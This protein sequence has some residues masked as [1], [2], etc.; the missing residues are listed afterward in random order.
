MVQI[1]NKPY[2][3][4]FLDRDG[5][6]NVERPDDYVKSVD[7]FV[8]E[9]NA[10]E[11]IA[12]LSSFFDHIFIITNQ[13]G[14]GRGIMSPDTLNDIHTYM[15]S[16]IASY[17]GRIDKIYCCTHTDPTCINRKPNTGMAFRVIGDYP[18][19]KF[20][21]TVMAGNSRS[22]ISFARKLGIYAVLVG[23][24]Y[25][26]RDDI[27]RISDACYEN[28]YKFALSLNLK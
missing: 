20:S 16:R 27:Y 12:I 6:I 17:G 4:L 7:E 23:D 24:K 8:F 26:A 5:V 13:R 19:V 11:A 3:T 1:G 14:V 28:L 22:D 25:P 9:E 21:E 18:Q 10:L 2:N 15:L